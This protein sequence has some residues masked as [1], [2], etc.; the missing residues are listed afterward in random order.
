MSIPQKISIYLDRFISC[1][2]TCLGRIRIRP[3]RF[4][5]GTTADNTFTFGFCLRTSEPGLRAG[6]AVER[7]VDEGQAGHCRH[8]GGKD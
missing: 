8:Q 5:P 3:K 2:M 4:E 6:Q 7:R 1:F